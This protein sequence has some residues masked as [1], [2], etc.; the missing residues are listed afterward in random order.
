M[1][2]E[3]NLSEEIGVVASASKVPIAGRQDRS[4]IKRVL[5]QTR[6][7]KALLTLQPFDVA[8]EQGRSRERY[9]RAALTTFTSVVARAVA[10]LT[11][12]L[13][14]RLTVRYLGDER[15]GLWM[16]ITSVMAMMSFADLGIG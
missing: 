15:Y 16:T 5:A 2:R 7:W 3:T 6:S 9:R 14:V 13:A 8:T 11:W 1:M 10:V 4:G 12:L